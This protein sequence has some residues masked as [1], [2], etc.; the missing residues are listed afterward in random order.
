MSKVTI[1]PSTLDPNTKIA[2]NSIKKRRVAAYARV[3]TDQD[4]QFTSFTA[5]VD[6]YTRVINSNPAYEMVEVYTDEGIS[7]TNMKRREGFNRMIE[8]A[9]AGK[10]D[11]IL[12]KSISRFARNTVDSLTTIR[13]LKEKG[14]EVFF[15]KENIYTFD[16]KGEL[17]ITIMSSIAQEESRSI[18][19]NVTWGKR[20]SFSDGKV[21][22]AWKN[23]LGYRKA[24]DGTI[25]IVPEEAE[26]VN[27]IYYT[28]LFEGLSP[29]V[30]AQKLMENGVLT[31]MGKTTWRA[32]GVL[33]ILKNEKYKGDA[34]LQK[35]FTVDFLSHRT[36]KNSGEIPQYYVKDSHPAIIKPA[37]WDLVQ[38]EIE[39]RGKLGPTYSAKNPFAFKVLCATCG[40][41]YGSA[42]WH[43]TNPR[44][45][46]IMMVRTG[47]RDKGT[48]CSN[49]GLSEEYIKQAFLK[50]IKKYLGNREELISASMS[51]REELAKDSPLEER[52]K[53]L[54]EDINETERLMRTI[55]EDAQMELNTPEEFKARYQP[56]EEKYNAQREELSRLL[57]EKIEKE[58]ELKVQEQM[59][60]VAK[61][62]NLGMMVYD[63]FIFNLFIDKA[64]VHK[65]RDIEFVFRTKKVVK[66]C[67]SSD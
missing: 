58:N 39:R 61:T 47:N 1:I 3:S 65:N 16:S 41:A 44:Y 11:L 48:K 62:M 51:I 32:N 38:F 18:S 15:E 27:Y 33:N 28:Y 9:L 37:M 59:E 26:I 56:I 46:K 29:A 52:I 8:D 64:L 66:V 45:K 14:V 12:T 34:L 10:I 23:F 53:I 7:G 24:L 22:I 55:V 49:P 30:I 4:E 50:A 63:K 43:S 35:T 40:E 5:Q 13:K 57:A 6:Y 36:K 42:T 67:Y 60:E 17:L 19:E 31:P 54:E 20:K 2:V 25:E 21:S